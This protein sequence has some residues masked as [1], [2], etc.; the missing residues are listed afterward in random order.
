MDILGLWKVTEVMSRSDDEICFVPADDNYKAAADPG[1]HMTLE[2]LMDLGFR[3][4][5][6]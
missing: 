3:Y 4:E 6:A 5:R 1:L 2:S